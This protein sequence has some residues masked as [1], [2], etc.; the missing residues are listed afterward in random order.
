MR[1]PFHR[2][3]LTVRF[4]VNTQRGAHQR[5]PGHHLRLSRVACVSLRLLSRI[6]RVLADPTLLQKRS[7]VASKISKVS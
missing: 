7:R 5:L 1:Q 2:Q 3:K 4:V 6:R